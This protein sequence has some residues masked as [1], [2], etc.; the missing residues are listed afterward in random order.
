M[1]RDI[2]RGV[3]VSTL[4]EVEACGGRFFD[5]GVEGDALAI[6]R[7]NGANLVRLRLWNDPFAEDGTPYGAGG[8]DL[9]TVLAL[10]ARAKAMGMPWMATIHYSDFWADPGKQ[11][12]PKAWRGM[13]AAALADAVYAYTRDAMLEMRRR[14]LVPA[15]VSI[16]NE[17]T[18]GLLWP[19]G[20]APEFGNIAAFVN[21]GLRAV[22]EVAPQVAAMIHLDR[23]GDNDMYRA[24][25]DRYF[26]A[27]GA[28]FDAIGLS[29]YPFWH[30]PMQGLADNLSDLAA[31][32]DKDLLVVETAMGFTL[33]DYGR[34]ER[35]P[36]DRRKGMAAKP[37]LA[38]RVD[39]PMTPA[40]QLDFLRDL[41]ATIRAV[42]GGR[43]LGFVY[44]EPAWLPVPGS[45]W[46]N[47]AALSYIGERGSGGNEWANLC[48]FDY[49]GNA[50]PAL[51]GL[52]EI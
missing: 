3:D 29:Y 7:D 30:G 42:P 40:G 4:R 31:R 47:D 43:G 9:V 11:R 6:L 24:W 2:I 32:Y 23:G 8:N 21:A 25:F 51:K 13:D 12:V 39:Y 37:A 44:W 36:E 45:E 17:I 27:G 19:L 20:K 38:A 22:R 50:L 14:D 28:D 33:E 48:L 10:A 41:A 49:D 5:G 35:L 16:G 15:Y 1:Q 52:R 18:N 46:A 26:A 34:R